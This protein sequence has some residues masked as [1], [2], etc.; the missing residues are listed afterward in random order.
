VALG[1][2]LLAGAGILIRSFD[3]LMTLRAGFDPTQV[4][5]ATLSLQ[6]GHGWSI[7]MRARRSERGS[8]RVH[9]G[10]RR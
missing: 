2:V 3:R 10:T 7:R 5:T 9:S 6:A 1:V 8:K 4:M